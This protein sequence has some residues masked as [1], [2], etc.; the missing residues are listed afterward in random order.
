MVPH[1]PI[2]KKGLSRRPEA[3]HSVTLARCVR[4]PTHGQLALGQLALGSL[5]LVRLR[6][7]G[8]MASLSFGKRVA[9]QSGPAWQVRG[10]GQTRSH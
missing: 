6:F 4:K 3:G 5:H 10:L 7:G 1:L 9:A 2:V 8:S